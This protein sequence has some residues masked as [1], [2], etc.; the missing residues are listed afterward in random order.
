[1]SE[2]RVDLG[3]AEKV[4][5]L[6]LLKSN[7]FPSKVGGKPSW[8][9][10]K[11]LPHDDELQCKKCGKPMIFLCQIYAPIE[12]NVSCF[13]R[14][15]FVFICRNDSC[16]IQNKN[17]NLVVFRSQLPIVNNFY[18][19]EAPI[20]EIKCE[21][22]ISKFVKTCAVCGNFGSKHCSK[23]KTRQYCCR[24][25]Q[26]IDWK[27]GHK[28]NCGAQKNESS[29]VKCL[30][31]E[32]ELLMEEE[33][34]L[35]MVKEAPEEAEARRLKEYEDFV[36]KNKSGTLPDVSDTD[37]ESHAAGSMDQ[38]FSKFRKR[39]SINP[40]QVLR[41]DRGG[42]PLWIADDLFPGQIPNCEYCDS[43]RQFEF[44]IMPQLLYSLHEYALD[45]G[46]LIVY[47]CKNSCDAGPSYKREYIFKQDITN[48]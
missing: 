21:F 34:I 43:E 48:K 14:T 1:M 37:L 38:T 22:E 33:Q 16:C 39:V 28:I 32:L 10:L 2:S 25:H 35:K 46:T 44:Q 17:S 11:A 13:H 36:A 41:Y 19:S 24:E 8:L 47:T 20:E 4:G 27:A 42:N 45:W 3:F 40:E 7:Y 26:L 23:C 15:I 5:S 6:W 18:P 31:N 29:D 12:E 9:D 30:F